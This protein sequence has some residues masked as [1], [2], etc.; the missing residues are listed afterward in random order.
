[1]KEERA[2]RGRRREAKK[3]AE[4]KRIC[5]RVSFFFSLSLFFS[6]L[7]RPPGESVS[8]L[9]C[10]RSCR[11]NVFWRLEEGRDGA[12]TLMTWRRRGSHRKRREKTAAAKHASLVVVFDDPDL[13]ATSA[14]AL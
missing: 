7:S 10:A 6:R 12:E 4:R 14:E 3:K 2:G 13:A 8:F 9:F 5:E 11:A 1:M